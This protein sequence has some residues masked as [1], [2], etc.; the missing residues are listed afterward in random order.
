MS[1]HPMKTHAKKRKRKEVNRDTIKLLEVQVEEE[2][3]HIQLFKQEL[4]RIQNRKPVNHFQMVIAFVMPSTKRKC[5]N[6]YKTR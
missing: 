2:E 3:A 4:D 5:K 1:N 6:N